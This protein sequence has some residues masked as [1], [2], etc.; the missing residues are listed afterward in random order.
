VGAGSTEEA[1]TSRL[2]PQLRLLLGEA[3]NTE[4]LLLESTLAP[5][6]EERGHADD[7]DE[8]EEDKEINEAAGEES[9]VVGEGAVDSGAGVAGR[10]GWEAEALEE[11]AGAFTICDAANLVMRM[12]L[13]M[14]L[15]GSQVDVL[16]GHPAHFTKYSLSP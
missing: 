11:E 6:E 1:G 15:R 3:A 9:K 12:G 8:E 10:G 16:S 4:L 7:D 5:S 14:C 13:R 2:E